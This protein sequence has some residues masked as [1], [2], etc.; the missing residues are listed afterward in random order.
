MKFTILF[1]A[2]LVLGGCGSVLEPETDLERRNA[3]C[4]ACLSETGC[5][6]RGLDAE[7]CFE[8]L[9]EVEEIYAGEGCIGEDGVCADSC[10][11]LVK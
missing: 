11:F 10:D 8:R 6:R 2:A 1:A 9:N 7:T 4:C 3:A 5:L